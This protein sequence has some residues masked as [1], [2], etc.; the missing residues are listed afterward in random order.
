MIPSPPSVE[1]SADAPPDASLLAEILGVAGAVRRRW[2]WVALATAAALAAAV[3]FLMAVTPRYLATAQLLIDPRA[4]RI[5]EGAVVPGGFGS[6]AAGADTLLVDSQVELI[7]SNTVLKKIVES[8]RLH[9]DAEFAVPRSGGGIRILLRNTIGRVLFGNERESPPA[10]DPVDTA[11]WRFADKHLRVR[12]PGNTYVINVSVISQDSAKAARLANAVANA[13]INDQVRA[14][15]DTTRDATAALQSR[16][17]DLRKRV[18][19]TESAVEAFRTQAGLIGSPNLLVTE[20]QLQQTNDKLILA[21]SQTALAKARYDQVSGLSA[22]AGAAVLAAQSDALKSPV[23]AN[24]RAS[25]SR[26]ERREAIAQQSLRPGHP[27]YANVLVEKRALLAQIE[28]ELARIKANARSELELAQ[29]NEGALAG[30]LKSLETRTAAGNQAQVRLRELQR[31]AQ[32][33]RAIFEQF[34]NR[35]KETSEQETLGRENSRIISAATV[36]P[37]PTFPPT[38]LILA[39][40][41]LAGLV[42]G[43]GT[44]WLAHLLSGPADAA[45]VAI[46]ASAPPP[47]PEPPSAA[48]RRHLRKLLAPLAQ[49]KPMNPPP[50]VPTADVA[51]AAPIIATTVPGNGGTAVIETLA[52]LPAIGKYPPARP[53]VGIADGPTFAD[54][55]AAVDDAS[56]TAYPGYREVI[57]QILAK[58]PRAGAAAGKPTICLLVGTEAAAG[59]SSTALALTYRSAIKGRRTLLIDACASDPHLSQVFA[60]NL[61]QRRACVLDSEAHLAEIT[62]QDARTG[63]SMLPIALADLARFDGEQQRRLLAGLRQL[64]QRFELVVIDTGA[65]ADNQA[66]AFLA[67]IADQVLIV[68]QQSSASSGL[69]RLRA[70]EAAR[71]FPAR[72]VASIVE[73]AA[74]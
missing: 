71:R 73:T 58:L 57:D 34:L 24:L 60:A 39:G 32:A 5:V 8:E 70:M 7:Q 9:E 25:L 51:N 50:R 12:R 65:A 1:R 2:A 14:T 28:E 61:K 18:E 40:A 69:S 67:A 74:A 36:P 66:M 41:L 52:R 63:L 44:A 38:L 15:G 68:T 56:A 59:T 23:I 16:I 19:T 29:S 27:E 31:E 54:H 30:E 17:E 22:R 11:V 3:L 48:P 46:P 13:Y 42:A 45:A 4:K 21:R 53:G 47:A 62:L 55:I 72:G 6:S 20:Q 43:I 10:T 64:M 26:V 49:P 35:A 33:A 37:Y